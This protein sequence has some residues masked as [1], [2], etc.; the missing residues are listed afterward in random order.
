MVTCDFGFAGRNIR[1]E[2]PA[3]DLAWLTEFLAPQFAVGPAARLDQSVRL[4]VDREQHARVAALGPHPDG[5]RVS[6]FTFDSG[7][8]LATLWNGLDGEWVALDETTGVFY[9]RPGGEPALVEVLAAEATGRAR[10]TVM[11]IVREFGIGY[12]RQA[13]SLLVH[14][15]ALRVGN[16]AFVIAGP[17]AAGKTTLLVHLLL[18]TGGQF[19]TNDRVAVA[20]E[21]SQVMA[22]GVPTIV[23]LRTSF[24]VWFPSLE[25][26]LRRSRYHHRFTL[27]E[28]EVSRPDPGGPPPSSP[29]SLSP[30]QF[31]RLLGTQPQAVGPVAALLFPCVAPTVPG[32]VVEALPPEQALDRLNDSLLPSAPPDAMFDVDGAENRRRPLTPEDLVA[33]LPSFQCRLGSRAYEEGAEWLEQLCRT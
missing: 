11:R 2:A 7:N 24:G 4:M 23:S 27:D 32:V 14:G 30:R 8:V 29:W 12:A 10:V 15:A 31:C 6:C 16:R 5:T 21:G 13:G 20:A 28:G 26:R 1:V 25:E 18:R 3:P 9:R 33:R 17:K 22:T 19:I